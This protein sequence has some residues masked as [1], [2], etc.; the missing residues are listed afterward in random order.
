[1]DQFLNRRRAHEPAGRAGIGRHE[2]RHSLR[3]AVVNRDL[4]AMI[5]NIEGEVL[6]HHRQA[7]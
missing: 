5:G 7:D 2:L 3:R 4:E 6:T 1:L